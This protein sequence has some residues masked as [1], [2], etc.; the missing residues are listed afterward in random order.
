MKIVGDENGIAKLKALAAKDK[1]YVKFLINEAKSN[2]DLI[3]PFTADDG[4]AWNLRIDVPTGDLF[5]EPK[6]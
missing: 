1:S 6:G 4:S 3:A 2:T 5:V